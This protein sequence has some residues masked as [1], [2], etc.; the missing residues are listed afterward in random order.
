MSN[1]SKINKYMLNRLSSSEVPFGSREF[2]ILTKKA[3][4][5]TELGVD[6]DE[7]ALAYKLTRDAGRSIGADVS[8]KSY[9]QAIASKVSNKNDAYYIILQNKINT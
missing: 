7:K 9:L 3:E 1:F 8:K 5:L 4:L 2:D 6:S